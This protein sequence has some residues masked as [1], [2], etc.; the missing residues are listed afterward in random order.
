VNLFERDVTMSRLSVYFLCCLIL[1][2]ACGDRSNESSERDNPSPTSPVADPV[3]DRLAQDYAS[4]RA[5]HDTISAVWE[6]LAAGEQ[7]QC[8]DY[9]T[10]P[11]PDSINAGDAA[12]LEPLAGLLHGA[13]VD[14]DSAIS[15]WKAECSKPRAL[16]SP[17]VI[18][19]GRWSAR[20][21]GDQL[22]EAGQ[23]L[24]QLRPE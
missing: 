3:L 20:A 12:D 14:L 17:D 21:A 11:A 23:R 8:G 9:P 16:P 10:A 22:K 2:S 1:L 13:A 19:R 18:D 7:A 24:A 15:L 4:L 5:A 6:T